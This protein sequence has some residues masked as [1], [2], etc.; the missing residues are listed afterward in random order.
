VV[1][2]IENPREKFGVSK[3]FPPV[4]RKPAREPVDQKAFSKAGINEMLLKWG[5][6]RGRRNRLGTTAAAR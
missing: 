3:K 1:A 4:K 5:N 6:A 2:D